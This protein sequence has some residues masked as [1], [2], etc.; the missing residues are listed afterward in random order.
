MTRHL[1][2]RDALRGF[3]VADDAAGI[4]V[5]N[6]ALGDHIE[7]ANRHQEEAAAN[8]HGQRAMLE[9]YLQSPTIAAHQPLVTALSLLPP[10]TLCWERG[11]P[12]RIFTRRALPDGRATAPLFLFAAVS[13]R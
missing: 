12:V 5:R 3:R 8:Q 9:D 10:L 13:N 4:V 6:K 2:E 1:F 7:E 11:R